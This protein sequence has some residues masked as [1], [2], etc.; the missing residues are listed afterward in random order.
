MNLTGVGAFVLSR[1]SGKFLFL[2]RNTIKYSNL[3]ALPGGKAEFSETLSETLI[4]ELEEEIGYNFSDRKLIPIDTYINNDFKYHTLLIIVDEEFV[5]ILNDEHKGF[6]WVDVD[7][8]PKP[9]HPGLKA[10]VSDSD[11][12][13]KINNIKNLI[14]EQ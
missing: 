6:C 14:K 3:W 4:R 2:L 11:V 5:P 12:I 10:L 13:Q 1:Y 8:V 7:S 9:T